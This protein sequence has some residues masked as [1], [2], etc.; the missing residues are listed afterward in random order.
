MDARRTTTLESAAPAHQPFVDL[1]PHPLATLLARAPLMVLAEDGPLG[2][3][4]SGLPPASMRRLLRLGGLFVSERVDDFF[5]PHPGWL[6]LRAKRLD[7]SPADVVRYV[8]A[9]VHLGF[10]LDARAHVALLRVSRPELLGSAVDVGGAPAR[11]WLDYLDA[12]ADAQSTTRLDPET[13]EACLAQAT[14]DRGVLG[15]LAAELC[16]SRWLADE[17]TAGGDRAAHWIAVAG[18]R[19]D[20]IPSRLLASTRLAAH[21]IVLLERSGDVERRVAHVDGLLAAIE[22]TTAEGAERYLLDEAARRLLAA[23]VVASSRGGSDSR[24]AKLARKMVALDPTCP[25]A[26]LLAGEITLAAT[27]NDRTKRPSIPDD[28]APIPPSRELSATEQEAQVYFARAE[29]TG[30]IERAH[31]RKRLARLERDPQLRAYAEVAADVAGRPF[32]KRE[33]IPP[34]TLAAIDA[35]VRSEPPARASAAEDPLARVRASAGYARMLPYWEL[36]IAPAS[37]S[38]GHV[39]APILAWK[40]FVEKRTPRTSATTMQREVGGL[41]RSAVVRAALGSQGANAPEARPVLDLATFATLS[42]EGRL[43]HEAWLNRSR[44]GPVDRANLGR[45]LGTLGFYEQAVVL[46]TI[47]PDRVRSESDAHLAGAYL[48]VLRR[49]GT[50]DPGNYLDLASRLFAQARH[51]AETL[52]TRLLI[53]LR[54]IGVATRSRNVAYAR[55]WSIRARDLRGEIERSEAL[56][57]FERAILVSRSYRATASAA[58]LEGEAARAREDLGL[59]ESLAREA[60]IEDA[61]SLDLKADHLHVTLDH[62]ARAY[63]TLGEHDRASGYIEELTRLDPFDATV[64]FARGSDR[65]A[66]GARE[67]ALTCFLRAARLGPDAAASLLAAG[68]IC[69]DLA[70]P[71]R[72][73]TCYLQ[74]VREDPHLPEAYVRLARAGAAID[75]AHLVAWA[76]EAAAALRADE[77]TEGS[78]RGAEERV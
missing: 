8:R 58:L 31:A 2:F 44:L 55:V 49:R 28:A 61:R 11:L 48:A 24:A 72:A 5:A 26:L 32:A 53:A 70:S 45:L 15:F 33:T 20:A 16:A 75:D 10:V 38:P 77:R 76:N 64:W 39:L 40:S 73:V 47:G 54:S 1:R 3:A 19:R 66:R 71:D 68:A 23:E 51:G 50:M 18:A 56:S 69:E 65:L 42:A 13:L 4:A 12:L 14:E 35:L 29:R 9:C 62:L 6:A 41:A 67:E 78:A 21:E 27:E 46:T 60:M 57:D 25:N 30:I 7:G 63:V 59:C 52:R 22:S 36:R 74:A 17:S 34:L 37:T 43:V